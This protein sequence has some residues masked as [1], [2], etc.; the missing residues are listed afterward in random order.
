MLAMTSIFKIVRLSM[1]AA[2]LAFS[3]IVLGLAAFFDQ[4]MIDNDLTHYIPLAIFVAACTLTI[5]PT[6]LVF[7][8]LKRVLLISQVRSELT[9]V[10]LLSLLWFILGIYTAVEPETIMTCDT[11]PGDFFEL[12]VGSGSSES[13]YSNETYQLQFQVLKS[14]A[15]LNAII[16]VVYF[17]FL[18]ILAYRQHHI[19]R[20]YIWHMGVT[21]NQFLNG[22]KDEQNTRSNRLPNPVTAKIIT[23]PSRPKR[24]HEPS[25]SQEKML[26]SS[27][28]GSPQMRPGGHYI[29]Y[30]PPPPPQRRHR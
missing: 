14:F 23:A 12:A 21:S 19:G 24:G 25:E 10:G 15:I 6:L 30:I 7:G 4:I 29:M 16:L 8:L 9:F 20:P 18:L 3:F 2:V 22:G 5:I 1:F 28:E 11:E 13:P 26:P 17:V 27:T